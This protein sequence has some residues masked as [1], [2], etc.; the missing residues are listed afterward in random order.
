MRRQAERIHL[1]TSTTT[2]NNVTANS[3]NSLENVKASPTNNPQ[4]II[5]SISNVSANSETSVESSVGIGS[6][7]GQASEQNQN[8]LET[9]VTL[10]SSK[11]SK[12][13]EEEDDYPNDGD[14][15]WDDVDKDLGD[16][17][18]EVEP[19][20]SSDDEDTRYDRF[21]NTDK[22]AQHNKD[23]NSEEIDDN[24]KKNEVK[25]KVETTDD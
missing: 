17:L 3:I 22:K 4:P 18:R 12:I 1:Q 10:A 14:K 15:L 8:S 13:Q 24:N 23:K 19:G 21:K 7:S 5:T 2:T 6:N 20:K 9:D 16:I 11:P 25:I